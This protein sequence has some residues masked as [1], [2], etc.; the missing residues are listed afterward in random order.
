MSNTRF[1]GRITIINDDPISPPRVEHALAVAIQ[2]AKD[3]LRSNLV[4]WQLIEV[5][6]V[7]GGFTIESTV[8]V[9]I[10][11]WVI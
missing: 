5:S 1:S 8:N 6:G 7:H 9:V 4:H 11:A 3:G 10:D 2:N